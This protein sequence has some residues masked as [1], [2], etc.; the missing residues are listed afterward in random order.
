MSTEDA[1]LVLWLAGIL[2]IALVAG[3]LLIVSVEAVTLVEAGQ[4]SGSGY[5]ELSASSDLCMVSILPANE[6]LL[7]AG[8]GT[9]WRVLQNGTLLEVL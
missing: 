9:L 5:H 4:F 6:S 7:E 8:N 2:S 3:A 1:I